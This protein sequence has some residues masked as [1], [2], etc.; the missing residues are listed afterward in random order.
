MKV[1]LDVNIGDPV[2]Y[3]EELSAFNVTTKFYNQVG[4]QVRD[5]QHRGNSALL[6]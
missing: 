5:L 4:P 6:N 2:V 3:A 1:F